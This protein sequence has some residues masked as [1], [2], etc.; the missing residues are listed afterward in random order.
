MSDVFEL[1]THRG[2]PVYTCSF[3]L[4]G[5]TQGVQTLGAQ[6]RSVGEAEAELAKVSQ[7]PL[8]FSQVSRDVTYCS[9]AYKHKMNLAL[10]WW[11]DRIVS[12]AELP[13]Q[14]FPPGDPRRG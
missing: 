11:D 8:E 13:P 2:V 9:T 14:W 7:E 6:F 10:V 4:Y 5:S 3:W 1:F 12:E